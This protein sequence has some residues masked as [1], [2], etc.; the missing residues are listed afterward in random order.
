MKDTKQG[1]KHTATCYRGAIMARAAL[2]QST[3][4]MMLAGRM[5][6]WCQLPIPFLPHPIHSAAL[7]RR[8]R[9]RRRRRRRPSWFRL[10]IVLLVSWQALHVCAAR[11]WLKGAASHSQPCEPCHLRARRR[12]ELNGSPALRAIQRPRACSSWPFCTYPMS[13]WGRGGEGAE[14]S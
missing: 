13:T 8:R 11:K 5:P 9:Q 3:T 14:D 10:R 12:F 4:R 1:R 6:R 7:R 2:I